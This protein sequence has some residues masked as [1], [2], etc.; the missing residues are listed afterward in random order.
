[1]LPLFK[2]GLA[3]KLGG[4]KQWIPWIHIDIRG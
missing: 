1:M 2:T 4:G 3:G